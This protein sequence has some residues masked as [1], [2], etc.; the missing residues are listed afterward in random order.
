MPGHDGRHKSSTGDLEQVPLHKIGLIASDA[1]R[2]EPYAT[3]LKVL[4]IDDTKK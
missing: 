2:V 3:P 1:L 4:P